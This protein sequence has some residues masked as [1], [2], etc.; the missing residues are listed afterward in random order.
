MKQ[1]SGQ[2]AATA[3][4]ALVSG[5]IDFPDPATEDAIESEGILNGILNGFLHPEGLTNYLATEC[6]LLHQ[7]LLHSGDL[8]A[9]FPLELRSELEN[10]KCL[11]FMF[12]TVEL[13][14]PFG[15]RLTLRAG[16]E[17][18]AAFDGA[19]GLQHVVARAYPDYTFAAHAF[20]PAYPIARKVVTQGYAALTNG[21]ERTVSYKTGVAAMDAHRAPAE[22]NWP[23]EFTQ[24]VPFSQA[25]MDAMRADPDWLARLPDFFN[26][27]FRH[28]TN[29]DYMEG[30]RCRARAQ[31]NP[32]ASGDA[33][34]DCQEPP[35]EPPQFGSCAV[36]IV[37]HGNLAFVDDV[38]PG[39][40]CRIL[41]S[42]EPPPAGSIENRGVAIP[43]NGCPLI[44][45]AG[46]DPNTMIYDDHALNPPAIPDGCD[47]TAPSTLTHCDFDVHLPQAGG[48]VAMPDAFLEY[49]VFNVA[50][51][52][53]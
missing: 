49:Y 33:A 16:R 29:Y 48:A 2:L 39:R 4:I 22:D 26:P 27:C 1:L 53:P 50:P 5:C 12:Y 8:T 28:L 52:G 31:P 46:R 43:Q 30:P 7:R 9:P 19:I 21:I 37:V 45:Y 47:F 18:V 17:A 20:T 35:R 34:A 36:P 44:Y 3:A 14:V 38:V 11:K 24:L 6:P 51:V 40:S 15:Q 32:R 10:R 41:K 25:A 42:S 13:M 23:R